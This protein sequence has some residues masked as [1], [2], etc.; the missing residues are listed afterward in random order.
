MCV[1]SSPGETV[2]QSQTAQG[3]RSRKKI[4]C[5]QSGRNRKRD[6]DSVPSQKSSH[7]FYLGRGLNGPLNASFGVCPHSGK[8][9]GLKAG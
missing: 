3:V 7:G 9:M 2:P 6:G 1:F 5:S 8:E 4:D